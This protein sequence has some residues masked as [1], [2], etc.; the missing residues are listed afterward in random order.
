MLYSAVV[1]RKRGVEALGAA[2][3]A[4][5]LAR[6]VGIDEHRDLQVLEVIVLRERRH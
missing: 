5:L 3:E 4:K 1:A 6:V 2:L